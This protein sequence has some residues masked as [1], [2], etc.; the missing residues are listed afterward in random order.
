MRFGYF[1]MPMHPPGS[2]VGVTLQTD[3]AQIEQLDRLGFHEAWIGEHFT[4]EWEN[5]PA[6][7]IFIGAALQRTTRIKLG[8]GVSCLP[9]HNPFHLAHRIAMLDQLAQGR[10]LWGIGSGGFPGDFEVAGIDPKTG[11][12]RQISVDVVDAVLA[13]WDDPRPG[14]YAEH[15]WAYHVPTEDPRIRKHV[16][17]KPLQQPH[18]PIAVAGVTEKSETLGLAGERGWIPMSINFVTPRVLRSHWA[19]VVEGAARGGRTAN[20]AEWRVCRAVHVAPTDEQARREALEGAVGRDYRDYFLPL[21]GQTRG[22]SGLKL[23]ES[24]SDADLT[25]EYLCDD[26][27]IV[28]SPATVARKIREL[29]AAVGGFGGLLIGATDWS[30]A[31]IWQRSMELF[32]AEVMPE[33]SD[34]GAEASVATGARA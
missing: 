4:A 17:L 31:T 2:D 19:S 16:Y 25:L 22:L 30:D 14:D 3:L 27:W 34:L 21:L 1:M 9:N 8:T 10:F 18:P 13:L 26:V 24:M 33:L 15:Y 6:P 32:A 5:I 11:I 29:H 12:Q 20:R 7:D 23:E 28:G